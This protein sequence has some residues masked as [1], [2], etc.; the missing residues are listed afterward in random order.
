[1]LRRKIRPP[2]KKLRAIQTAIAVIVNS[3]CAWKLD[4]RGVD[5][6]TMQSATI[7]HIVIQT[8]QN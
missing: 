6:R 1:M 5:Y 7:F 8:S 3:I 2:S 4:D